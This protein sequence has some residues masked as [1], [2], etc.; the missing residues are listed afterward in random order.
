LE[1]IYYISVQNLKVYKKTLPEPGM[2]MPRCIHCQYI[3]DGATINPDMLVS[4]KQMPVRL[5]DL[6]NEK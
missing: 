3:T 2:P 1:S 4:E 5:E 6:L